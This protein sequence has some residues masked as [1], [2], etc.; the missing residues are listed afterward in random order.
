MVELLRRYSNRPELLGPLVSALEKIK[1]GVPHDDEP[2]L[3][4]VRSNEAGVWRVA[5]RLSPS[6]V[7]ALIKSYQAGSTARLLAERYS[8]STATV[9][10]LLREHGVRKQRPRARACEDQFR[11][12]SL[13]SAR[14]RACFLDL[15]ILEARE[16]RLAEPVE[17]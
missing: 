4:P 2:D 3:A 8:V 12:Q 13:D 10:R 16:E 7:S 17:P 5:D 6:D 11:M 1:S 15:G 14:G 9:K